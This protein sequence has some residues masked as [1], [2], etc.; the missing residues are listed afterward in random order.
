MRPRTTA[1]ITYDVWFDYARL[2]DGALKDLREEGATQEVLDG[3]IG[4]VRGVYERAVSHVPPGGEKRHG[5][6]P[7]ARLCFVQG[8]R[9]QCTSYQV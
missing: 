8:N 3:S 7:M 2:E 6:R 9:N 4:H 5:R 1:G